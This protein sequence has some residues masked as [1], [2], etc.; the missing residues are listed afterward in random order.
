MKSHGSIPL[1][2][3]T[4]VGPKRIGPVL[5]IL[6]KKFKNPKVL[7]CVHLHREEG[8]LENAA[9]WY[10]RAGTVKSEDLAEEWHEIVGELLN[11]NPNLP[12]A[13]FT[14]EYNKE[15]KM[16]QTISSGKRI[17]WIS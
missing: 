12:F 4:M 9:Y 1:F 5:M 7:G 15:K 10:S 3:S 11:Y 17:D 6:L 16:D 2:A 8:D 14:L 13:N